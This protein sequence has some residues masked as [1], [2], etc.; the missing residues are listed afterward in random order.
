M[1]AALAFSVRWFI[2][3]QDRPM[4]LRCLMSLT[5]L[6]NARSVPQSLWQSKAFHAFLVAS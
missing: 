4:H 5:L 3:G 2:I 6:T 1:Q